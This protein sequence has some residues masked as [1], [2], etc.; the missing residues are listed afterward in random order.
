MKLTGTRHIFAHRGASAYAPENTLE[1]FELAADMNAYG[2]ELDVHL[3]KDNILVVA[4]DNDIA[5]VSNGSGR[6]TDLTFEELRSF[7]FS[8]KFPGEKYK[9]LKIPTLDEVY[10]L[11]GPRGLYVNVEIKSDSSDTLI[12][13]KALECA[14]ENGMR[15]RVI[16]SSF[17]H[18]LLTALLEEEP[19]TFVAPL[20]GSEI[21]KPADYAA[22]FGAKAI[23]PHFWQII[24]HPEIVERANEL[25]VRVHPWTVDDPNHIRRLCELNVGAIIT[26]RPD[27]ALKIA[28]ELES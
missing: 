17:N 1:A 14:K 21:V 18:W 12:V 22:L 28:S 8:A 19:N 16:Y 15:E 25:G 2:V 27:V 20:Y 7:D 24:S 5:R 4:H 26:N 3:T 6:I 10:K 23:H 9:G 13:R 11:L